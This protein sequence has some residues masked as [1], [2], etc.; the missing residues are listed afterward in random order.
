MGKGKKRPWIQAKIAAAEEGGG[1]KEAA[2]LA[3]AERRKKRK[4]ADRAARERAFKEQ[5]P[6]RFVDEGEDDEGGF[7]G[8]DGNAGDGGGGADATA[9][10]GWSGP[11]PDG[12]AAS[13]GG[14]GADAPEAFPRPPGGYAKP[15]RDRPPP[16]PWRDDERTDV[17]TVP[18]VEKWMRSK[19]ARLPEAAKEARRSR[20]EAITRQIAAAAQHKQLG[21]AVNHFRRLVKHER[22]IPTSYTYATL[23]NAYVNSGDV[24]GAEEILRRMNAVPGMA[25]NVVVYT[26]MLKGH[27]LSGDVRKAE[28]LV[29]HEMPSRK[30]PVEMDARAVNTFL[31]V[32]QR[33]GDAPRAWAAYRKIKAS[34][35]AGAATAGWASVVPDDATY[36]LV[37]RLLSQSLSLGDLRAVIADAAARAARDKAARVAGGG[38]ASAAPCQFWNAGGCD[39]GA[40]CA[41]FHDPEKTQRADVE[42]ADAVAAMHVNLAHCA[43][44]LDE[45]EA[46]RLAIERANDALDEAEA[47]ASKLGEPGAGGAGN[48]DAEETQTRDQN[49][50]IKAATLAGALADSSATVTYKRTTRAELRLELKR[51]GGFLKRVRKGAQE[52]PDVAEYL[53][54][55]LVFE[56]RRVEGPSGGGGTGQTDDAE[57]DVDTLVTALHERLCDAFGLERACAVSARVTAAAAKARLR[58]ALGDDGRVDFAALF[59]RDA[60]SARPVPHGAHEPGLSHKTEKKAKKKEKKATK[61]KKDKKDKENTR[62]DQQRIPIRSSSRPVKLEIC[63]GNGDWAVAQAL[64][65]PGSDWV[66]LEL[67]HDRVYS[68]F[69][70]A[71]CEGAPNLCAMGGDAASVLRKRVRPESVS[72]VFVN[73]PEP[74]HHSGDANAVNEF[75]LLTPD[76]FRRTHAALVTGGGLT[77][78]SDNHRY[79]RDL[80]RTLAELTYDPAAGDDPARAGE[81]LFA[82]EAAKPRAEGRDALAGAAADV[83]GGASF[84]NIEGVRLYRGVPGEG[85]GHL[86]HEQSYFDRFWEQGARTERFFAVVSKN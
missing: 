60:S 75:H 63:A 86:V 39:R 48:A 79:M 49:V 76:F 51:V 54:R 82:A 74:P 67:R 40:A 11:D 1:G 41:F 46:A 58:G 30:P 15:P 38:D 83:D 28:A 55:A 12:N 71:V 72:H 21:K 80:A 45:A 16:P 18:D 37:A 42:A 34:R 17:S 65:D 59:S 81:P 23:L 5:N 4:A 68:I 52:K 36:K 85:T 26:T 29:Y 66:A 9:D 84:E 33:A 35:D 53:T 62:V 6:G 43:A 19:E 14:S 13:R 32:C 22:L 8:R 47:L 24:R 31:R 70:R 2:V 44:L 3:E 69:S 56:N 61:D 10:D 27:M 64:A 25:P 50:D 57:T 73:F 7:G 77:L 20:A 78:F